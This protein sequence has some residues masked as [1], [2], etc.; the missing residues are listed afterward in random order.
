MFNLNLLFTLVSVLLI[1]NVKSFEI[2]DYDNE[3]DDNFNQNYLVIHAKRSFKDDKYNHYD[4]YN[5]HDFVSDNIDYLSFGFFTNI[6]IGSNNDTVRVLIDTGSSDFWVA[7]Y[8]VCKNEEDDND[9]YNST[10]SSYN[11]SLY[12]YFDS[13]NSNTFISNHTSF[14]LTYG[15]STY[16]SG[17][18]GRDTVTIG[19]LTVN[20]VNLAIANYTN[21]SSG[22]IGIGYESTEST[23]FFH[24]ISKENFEYINFPQKL[25]EDGLIYKASYSLYLDERGD[26]EIIFG[27]VDHNKYVGD[28]YEFPIVPTNSSKNASITRISITLN[29]I[30]IIDDNIQMLVGEG[31]VPVVL[32]SGTTFAAFPIGIAETM[33]EYLN[34]TYNDELGYYF[35]ENCSIYEGTNLRFNFQG[36]LFES[37]LSGYLMEFIDEDEDVLGCALQISI[38]AEDFIILGDA[39]LKDL[40]TVIDLDDN[41]A[42]LAYRNN[43]TETNDIE[44][45]IDE[46]PNSTH[47]PLNETFG[48]DNFLFTFYNLG[49]IEI[50]TTAG[51]ST[52]PVSLPTTI[53]KVTL[54]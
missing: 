20:D 37:P 43:D 30:E 8:N 12:G 54:S 27:A 50:T 25:V 49:P 52:L 16:A 22:V 31:Y 46:I 26:A 42:A 19:N 35:T 24:S 40:Y 1:S 34:M 47:P 6:Q 14:F 9:D 48:S 4:N 15:D 33:A 53:A 28:L 45:I 11:C 32:D 3:I 38:D 39:F 2:I 29:E 36:A 5:D 21:S 44:V 18:F 10:S 51:L 41:K 23:D 13:E 17:T 7:D